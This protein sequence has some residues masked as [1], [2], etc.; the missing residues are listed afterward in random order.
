[1][2]TYVALNAISFL[3]AGGIGEGDIVQVNAS[4][5]AT[6]GNVCFAGACA[7]IGV[8]V[9]PLGLIEPARTLELLTEKRHVPGKKS[10]VSYMTTYASYLG[11]L[12]ECGIERG[13]GPHDFGLERISV[14]GEL[15]SEG[16]KR[17]ARRL[18]GDDVRFDEDYG[19]TELWPFGGQGCSEGHLHFEPTAGILEVVDPET[20]KPA[21]GERAG[22]IVATPLPPYR[23]IWHRH[24]TEEESGGH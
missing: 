14:G 9:Y 16:L 21:K 6:L 19:I 13:Y 10:R 18:F 17:R 8:L 24:G 7:H 5:R 23:E 15:V 1:M 4:S 20:R 12:A 2:R 3:L 22:T 11:E